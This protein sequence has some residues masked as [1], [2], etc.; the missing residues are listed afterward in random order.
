MLDRPERALHEFLFEI[1]VSLFAGDKISQHSLHTT[2]P[3]CKL[4]HAFRER[5]APKVSVKTAAHL[6]RATQFGAE[7][8]TPQLFIRTEVAAHI[9]LGQQFRGSQSIINALARDRI[10]ETSSI[11]E[12]GPIVAARRSLVPRLCCQTWNAR[13]VTFGG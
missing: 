12:Q 9:S 5:R 3:A 2:M 7:V 13:R 8:C 10:S 11:A 4:D 1:R 6:G